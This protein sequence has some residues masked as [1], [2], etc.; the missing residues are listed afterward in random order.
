MDTFFF[1]ISKLGWYAFR[2]DVLLV[3]FLLAGLIC[4]YAG[5]RKKAL[6]IL[7]VL[8]LFMVGIT[9][10]PAG[11]WLLSPLESRF[12][13]N[14][15][16]PENIDGIIVL[17]GAEDSYKGALWGQVALNSAADRL[18]YFM[19][20]MRQ[21]PDA[22]HV[23]SGGTGSLA[24]QG[25]KSSDMARQ[26]FLELGVDVDRIRFESASRNTYEN[27]KFSYDMI[28]PAPGEQWVL[29]TTAWHMPRAVGVFEKLGWKVIPFPVDHAGYPLDSRPVFLFFSLNF[30][31]NLDAL[32]TG[33][34]EWTGLAVYYLTGKTTALL[35]PSPG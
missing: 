17:A 7:T 4:L 21:Y 32:Q 6:A 20:L 15:E 10:F 25:Y 24:T 19:A 13:T 26:M 1:W 14:P 35:P 9:V 2:P 31:G 11:K 3:G 27:G 12:P 23:F 8:A 18:H 22:V 28:K 30:T 33:L 16:L 29:V 34:H 5:A